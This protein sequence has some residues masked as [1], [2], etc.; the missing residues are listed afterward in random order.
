MSQEEVNKARDFL[1]EL[2]KLR[3]FHQYSINSCEGLSAIARDSIEEH[4]S[5]RGFLDM[6]QSSFVRVDKNL[7]TIA[8]WAESIQ[9]GFRSNQDRIDSCISTASTLR[10]LIIIWML[11]QSTIVIISVE[12]KIRP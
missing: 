11:I 9:M 6:P 2:R 7:R 4:N 12:Y 8:S 3:P 1:L 10:D 5:A